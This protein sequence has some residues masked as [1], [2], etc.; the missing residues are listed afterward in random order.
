MSIN[1][2]I[3]AK[4][5]ISENEYEKLMQKYTE[6]D[7][8]KQVNYY[9]FS[10]KL[11]TQI[12]KFGL[13]VRQKGK[14]FELTL[15]VTEKVGKTEINQIISRKEF[16]KLKYF[17][18]FP[19]G[20]VKNYLISNEVCDPSKLKIAGK[21]VTFRT[22]LEFK[23]S[24]ISIDKS[25]Y[26]H[27]I[28]YEIESESKTEENAKSSLKKFLELNQIVYKKSDQSKLGRFISTKKF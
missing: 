24:L 5:M 4:C 3:E 27:H 17:K 8:H 21:L 25:K 15:K 10:S 18:I 16:L 1:L 26:N 9:I 2:E 19:N 14:S 28:D 23:G 6:K 22:D 11:L 13:R 20:E 12:E 7:S